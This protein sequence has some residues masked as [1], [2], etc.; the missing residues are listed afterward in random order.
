MTTLQLANLQSQ[1]ETSLDRLQSFLLSRGEPTLLAK[2]ETLEGHRKNLRDR[3]LLSLAFSGQY[4]AGK[5]TII[6]ALTGEKNI[7][8]SADVAT[9]EV[10]AYRWREIELWDTPGLYADRADHTA[11]AEQAQR[12]ADLIVYCL[13]TNLFD[14]VTATDFRRLAFEKGYA[15]KLFLLI[16]KLSMEDVDD[17][18]AFIRNLTASLDRTLSPHR[19]GE[20]NHA[21]IDAQDYRDGLASSNSDLIRFSQF[22]ACVDQLND[23][24]KQRG[25]LAR[26]DPPIRLGLSTID[27]ALGSLPEQTFEQNPEL[28]LLNQQL[29]IVQNQQRRT[30]AEVRRLG[31]GI[32]HQMQVLGEQ[33]L[34][35]ELGEE[36]KLAEVSFQARCEEINKAAFE[37]LN[38]IIQESYEKLEA[39]LDDFANE[40]FVADYFASVDA[41]KT[42]SIPKGGH[43]ASRNDASRKDASG[44][45]NPIKGMAKMLLGKGA[46]KFGLPGGIMS[47]TSQVADGAGHQMIYN[48]GKF[49]GKNFKPWEA[50]KMAK[51]L[52]QAV[53]ILG[54]VVT[55]YE[56]YEQVNEDA[57]ADERQRQHDQQLHE[58][59][60][61]VHALA[62]AMDAQLRKIYQQEYDLPVTGV[63]LDCLNAERDRVLTQESTNKELVER[64][65]VHRSELKGYLQQLYAVD[66]QTPA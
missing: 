16:N 62:E 32:L 18:T 31:S 28:F 25:L 13:T 43:D 15:P 66:Q 27:E 9:D 17:T 8:I 41:S 2:A 39:K 23:W 46:E 10:K 29:R 12:E 37:E 22:E 4:S 50:V 5:S 33:L 6:S 24:I 54:I 36:P 20:F 53:A 42:G 57:K 48:V 52:G 40:P 56:V 34:S 49:F 59:R 45:E 21:F 3:P 26:L 19:L 30:E 7:R 11:K 35:G 60:A 51:G 58:A 61:Q 14:N 38:E 64:L 44:K 47:K 65:S 63:I 55:A 1:I